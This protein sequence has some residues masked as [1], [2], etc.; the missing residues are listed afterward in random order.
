MLRSLLILLLGIRRLRLVLAE[1]I[2]SGWTPGNLGQKSIIHL[3]TEI[4]V[5]N[6]SDQVGVI[7]VRAQIGRIGFTLGRA[8]QDCYF[9]DIAGERVWAVTPGVLITE[10]T[11]AAMQIIHPFETKKWSAERAG[12]VWFR[13]VLTDQFN[14]RHTKRLR[15]ERFAAFQPS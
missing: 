8:L 10:R 1:R 9:C 2:L 12:P 13:V 11:T 5:T 3:R 14:R 15:F 7:V 6:P 4:A